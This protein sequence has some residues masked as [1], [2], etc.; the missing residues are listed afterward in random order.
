MVSLSARHNYYYGI[1][2]LALAARRF[3]YTTPQYT[4]T[5]SIFSIC[6]TTK[7]TSVYLLSGTFLTTRNRK[8]ACDVMVLVAL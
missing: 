6:A 2:K 4:K 5:S 8:G 7:L 1:C 3:K